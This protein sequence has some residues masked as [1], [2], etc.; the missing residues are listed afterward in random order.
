MAKFVER[1]VSF[2]CHCGYAVRCECLSFLGSSQWQNCPVQGSW[3]R[4]TGSEGYVGGQ[5]G[6]A[7]ELPT[8]GGYGRLGGGNGPVADYAAGSGM[9]LQEDLLRSH[10]EAERLKA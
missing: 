5:A 8:S 6:E 1:Q 2:A 7:H 9:S 3:S 10:Q 4:P